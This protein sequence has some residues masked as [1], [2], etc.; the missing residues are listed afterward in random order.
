MAK[1]TGATTRQEGAEQ[2][3][4][5]LLSTTGIARIDATLLAFIELLDVSLPGHIRACYLGGSYSDGSAV[6]QDRSPNSSDL[7]V[8]VIFRGTLS[9]EALATFQ[10]VLGACRLLSPV[11]LDAQAYS[12]DD[13]VWPSRPGSKQSS[14]VNTLIRSAGDPL[15]GDDVRGELPVVQLARFMLDVLESGVYHL[16]IPRQR[17]ELSYPLPSPLEPPLTYPDFAG[18]FYGYD[19]V[20]ARPAAPR[21]TRVLVDIGMWIGTLLLAAETARYATTKSQCAQGCREHLPHDER[22]Q[23]VVALYDTCK[24]KWAYTVPTQEHERDRLRRWC[25]S[26]LELENAYLSLCRQHVLAQLQ[27]GSPFE[28]EQAARILHSVIYRDA[29]V[30]AALAGLELS[31]SAPV[32]AAARQ[33]LT[34]TIAPHA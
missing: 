23:L 31:P 24:Q 30:R 28:Q 16:G 7:D 25:A 5:Q 6:G 4:I 3:A 27:T 1:L 22:A 32:R 8:Y 17:S 19:V 18:E 20:P 10:R 29:E 13:F 34:H 14:F 26:L 33:A 2:V 21:G 15:F 9:A 11:L 12:E